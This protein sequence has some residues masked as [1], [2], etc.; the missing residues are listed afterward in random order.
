MTTEA[1]TNLAES[2][3]PVNFEK[4]GRMARQGMPIELL[5]SLAKNE[6]VLEEFDEVMLLLFKDSKLD[7]DTIIRHLAEEGEDFISRFV[8][9]GDEVFKGAE[10]FENINNA[11]IK[12]Q[13]EL[14]KEYFDSLAN[15]GNIS[16]GRS[17]EEAPLL[18]TPNSYYKTEG[19][20]IIVYNCRG[21]KLLDISRERIKVW[22]RNVNPSDPNQVNWSS[23]KLKNLS[24]QVEETMQWILD[25][26]KLGG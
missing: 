19:G 25:Y 14:T 18:A 9:H 26:F 17:G 6:R 23:Y 15:E 4:L 10:I 22:K 5:E 13:S 3:K 21:E 20:H 11:R 2:L 24:G 16:G 8:K 12:N 1:I 7:P